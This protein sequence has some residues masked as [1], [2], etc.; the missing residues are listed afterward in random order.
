MKDL[1]KKLEN[2]LY[3]KDDLKQ[4]IKKKDNIINEYEWLI[5]NIELVLNTNSY[6]VAE[7]KFRKITELIKDKQ[8]LVDIW[9][10]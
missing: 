7:W 8:N 3:E 6:G 4:E 1:I 9:K 2:K 10:D 5:K